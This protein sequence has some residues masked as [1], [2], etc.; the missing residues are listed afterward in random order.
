MSGDRTRVV[1]ATSNE[2]KLREFRAILGD[3]EVEWVGLAEAGRVDFPEEGDDYE[4]NAVAKARA[5]SDQL[6]LPAVADDSGLEVEG[7]GG[8]PGPRSARYGGDGLDDAG[9]VAHL[10]SEMAGLEGEA[11]RA[12]FVCV[13]ALSTPKG[14]LVVADGACLGAIRSEPVGQGGFGYDPVFEI[15]GHGRTLAELPEQEK[16]RLSHRG[17]ALLGLRSAIAGLQPRSRV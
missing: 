17:R 15:P 2:G 3:L 8:E 9:R 10:L 5:A 11:R 1:V 14:V 12:R 6:G 16:N 7:L 4:A 13:A